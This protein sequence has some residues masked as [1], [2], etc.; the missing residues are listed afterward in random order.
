MEPHFKNVPV[1]VTGGCGF[2]GSHLVEKLVNLGAK[3]TILDNLST[4]HLENIEAVKNNITLIED[5][6]TDS[7]ACNKA[8]KDQQIIF[9]LAALTS[10]SDAEQ[11][12]DLCTKI[13]VEG[14]QN[15]L[16][17]A[18]DNNVKRFI[19]SSSASVYGNNNGI[20]TEET[21]CSPI[22]VYGKSKLIGEQLCQEFSQKHA[23]KTV[24]LRYFNVYGQ[25]QPLG[26][27][28]A[29]IRHCM[30][31]NLPITIFGNAHKTRDFVSVE[32]VASANIRCA[33]LE[34]KK[35]NSHVFNIGTGKSK[36][37]V[38]LINELKKEF[39]TFNAG[40]LSAPAREG[41]L[42]HSC[43]DCSKYRKTCLS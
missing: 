1:L 5:D 6:I 2:I 16:Q 17:A 4:G 23:L 24:M 37:L 30:L 28:L 31:N 29:N 10:V 39:A 41:D 19:F 34:S 18:L 20:C 9:H 38:E 42:E 21:S 14:T 35:V 32:T 12:P 8:T 36:S 27:I 3:V 15:L 13:N 25:R 7:K 43:A 22:S 33:Q 40:I 26:S 11:D